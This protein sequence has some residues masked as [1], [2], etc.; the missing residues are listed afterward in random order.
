MHITVYQLI[1]VI[2]IALVVQALGAAVVLAGSD[3]VARWYRASMIG[4][5]IGTFLILLAGFGMLARLEIT[6]AFPGWVWVKLGIW[7]IV[8]ALPF[9]LRRRPNLASAAWALTLVLVAAA[10]TM[11]IFKPL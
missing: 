1:H 8:A 5:G 6:G 10:A 9:L 11:A 2:G 7:V 3:R 4:H